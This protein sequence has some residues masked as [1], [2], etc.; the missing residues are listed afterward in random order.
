MNRYFFVSRLC[1]VCIIL[2]PL[3]IVG[4]PYLIN[5][6]SLIQFLLIGL[7]LHGFVF[8]FAVEDS[9][10]GK[11]IERKLWINW[12]WTP[13]SKLLNYN[14][15]LLDTETKDKYHL[16]LLKC[17]PTSKKIDFKTG[18][19]YEIDSI[20]R[21]WCMY[22]IKRIPHDN[23]NILLN[24]EN[25]KYGFKRHL[26]G[27]K[28]LSINLIIVLIIGNILFY[29]V[30]KSLDLANFPFKFYI[31]ELL[32]I[33]LLFFWV[34]FVNLDWVKKSAIAYSRELLKISNTL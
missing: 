18:S 25:I 13:I 15:N 11:R 5:Y 14:N 17:L 24:N 26:W 16:I 4:S 33:V 6:K 23:S 2:L 27:Y 30:Y 9:N 1:P 3:F 20:Y 19:I 10:F 34:F 28:T 29:S 12:G 7:V 8:F 21:W 31:T 32:L 22:L